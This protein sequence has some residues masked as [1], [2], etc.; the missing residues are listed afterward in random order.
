MTEYD[1]YQ[2]IEEQLE[3]AIVLEVSVVLLPDEVK[4]LKGVLDL[5]WEGAPQW[6]WDALIPEEDDE[7]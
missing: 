7:D 5:L 2:K 4:L 3:T 6:V 1:K